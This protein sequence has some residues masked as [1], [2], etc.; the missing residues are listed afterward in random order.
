MYHDPSTL[1]CHPLLVV[2]VMAES[3]IL[4][5]HACATYGSCYLSSFRERA[6][7]F[8]LLSS[9]LRIIIRNIHTSFHSIYAFLAT[10]CYQLHSYIY[11]IFTVLTAFA[12]P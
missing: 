4:D 2:L 6:R 11:H 5:S 3:L 8:E 10:Q 1:S 9:S 7:P 12:P